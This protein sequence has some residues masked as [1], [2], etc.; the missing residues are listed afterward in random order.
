MWTPT[1]VPNL[2]DSWFALD[3]ETTGLGVDREPVEI[4]VVDATGRVRFHRLVRPRGA[5]EPGARKLHGLTSTALDG[6]GAFAS[7]QNELSDLLDG[8]TVIA[9]NASFDREV[10]ERAWGRERAAPPTSDWICALDWYASWRGFR[11]DLATACEVERLARPSG[12]RALEDATALHRL[13]CRMLA[14]RVPPPL[15]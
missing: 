1:P 7:V 11:A 9:Y 10:L 6:Q 14:E 15:L 8:R 5:M 2:P 12:H 3:T 4:A 13:V